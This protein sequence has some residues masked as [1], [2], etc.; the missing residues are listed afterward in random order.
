MPHVQ[1]H[2]LSGQLLVFNFLQNKS[3]IA[4]S[5]LKMKKISPK[6]RKLPKTETKALSIAKNRV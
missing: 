4:E 2:D 3:W 6:M 5:G 1:H